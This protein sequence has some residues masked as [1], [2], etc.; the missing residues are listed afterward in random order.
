[1]SVF[2]NFDIEAI[3]EAA[4]QQ[5]GQQPVSHMSQKS[6]GADVPP[7]NGGETQKAAITTFTAPF[8]LLEQDLFEERAA[9]LEYDEDLPPAKAEALAKHRI[10]Q[11]RK[12]GR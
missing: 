2:A 3:F 5:H 1:M 9:T 8:T 6:Q 10:L 12:R 7:R 11:S 4:R